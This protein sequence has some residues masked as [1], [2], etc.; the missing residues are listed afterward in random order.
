MKPTSSPRIK[1]L[2]LMHL[3][4]YMRET[5]GEE[6]YHRLLAALPP[7]VAETLKGAFGHE[8]YPLATL[9]ECEKT[10]VDMFHGGDVTKTALFGKYDC[11]RQIGIYRVVLRHLNTDFLVKRGPLIWKNYMDSGECV[12]RETGDRIFEITLSGYDPMHRVHCYDAAG[13][14][15]GAVEVCGGKSVRVEHPTC[16]LEGGKACVYVC[17][18][19]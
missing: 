13:S 11:A 15:Q 6:G 12:S 17:R 19:E 8:W 3:N 4:D 10:F 2:S 9:V 5:H 16:R 18:W 7:N 1:G 14:F